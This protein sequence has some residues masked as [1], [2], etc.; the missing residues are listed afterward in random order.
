MIAR[1]SSSQYRRTTKPPHQIAREL[2]VDYLL[3]AT[4]RWERRPGGESRVRVSPELVDAVSG[5]TRWQQPFDAPLTDVFR[6]QADV[7]SRVAEALGVALGAVER[8]RLAEQ[9]TSNLEAYA[10]YLRG[11]ELASGEN[12]P[13]TLRRAAA[14]YR[15]AVQL[16]STFAAAWA[17]LAFTHAVL[18]RLGGSQ[19]ADTRLAREAVERAVA[20]A[21]ES[22]DTRLAAA[23]YAGFLAGQ[24]DTVVMRELRA[25]LE[26]AP[27][28]TDLLAL[29]GSIEVGL[30]HEAQGLGYLEHAVRLDPLS[31]DPLGALALIYLRLH[32]LSEAE[33]TITRARALRPSSIALAYRHAYILA[34]KGDLDGIRRVLHAMEQKLGSRPVVA[35]VA[36]REDLITLLDSAQLRLMLRLTPADLDN[37]RADW[38]LALAEGHWLLGNMAAARAYGDTATAAYAAQERSVGAHMGEEDQALQYGLHALALAYAGRAAD[39]AAGARR[40]VAAPGLMYGYVHKLV[41]RT[42]LLTGYPEQALNHIELLIA[43]PSSSIARYT[44]AWLRI[45]PAFAPLRGDARFEQL[46]RGPS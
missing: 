25:G 7:A 40:A 38:A 36:L 35:Y 33:A 15:A 45:D 17:A 39:A 21:P 16:D 24:G 14:E 5:V 42:Y 6:V 2:A 10:H 9:P 37:G 27:N 30:G 29:A 20:L 31:P 46:A 43:A 12:T 44:P 1:A 11:R 23:R 18:F 32:R 3:T 34:A 41:A 22:P 8:Q 4:V 26:V 19:A 13:E 28:R